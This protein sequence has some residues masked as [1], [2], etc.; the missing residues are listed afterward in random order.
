MFKLIKQLSVILIA[1]TM[2]LSLAVIPA[3]AA[4]F[5]SDNWAQY[6][7]GLYTNTSSFKECFKTYAN[8]SSG[9]DQ[10]TGVK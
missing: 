2:L 10:L 7:R 5:S 1:V 8:T 9:D 3:S 4:T 6:E